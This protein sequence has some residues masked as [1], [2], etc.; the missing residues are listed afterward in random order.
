[1][2]K[3]ANAPTN[4]FCSAQALKCCLTPHL[5]ANFPILM[6]RYRG[7]TEANYWLILPSHAWPD[8]NYL[9]LADYGTNGDVFSGRCVYLIS[10]GAA[11]SL[12]PVCY[13]TNQWGNNISTTID[14][15]PT[16]Q[17]LG[18]LRW[19]VAVWFIA[20]TGAHRLLFLWKS[21]SL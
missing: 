9:P 15:K 11:H 21:I 20:F 7:I 6:L 19:I 16:K 5:K 13:N 18:R 10:S 4:G 14:I 3:F 12:R 2:I 8:V 17:Y 1:M